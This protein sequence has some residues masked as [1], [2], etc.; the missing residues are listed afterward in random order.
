[1]SPRTSRRVAGTTAP[2]ALAVLLIACAPSPHPVSADRGVPAAPIP[3]A[4]TSAA[5][6]DATT[7]HT[8]TTTTVPPSSPSDGATTTTALP[9]SPTSAPPAAPTT[10]PP[11][12]PTTT[13][14][15]ASDDAPPT[16]LDTARPPAPLLGEAAPVAVGGPIATAQAGERV[17]LD[18]GHVDLIEVTV[19]GARLVVQLKDDTRP[20]GPV[21]R[22]P[23]EVQARVGDAARLQVP[24][25]PAFSFLGPAGSDLWMLPQVQDPA[26]LWPGWSTERISQGQVAGDAVTLRL[27]G[28][29]GPGSFA[30]FTTDQFG[31]PSVIFD[32]DGGVPNSTTVPIRT[33]AHASWAFGAEGVYRVTF[34]V[35]AT[36]S[37][38]TG[39]STPATYVVLVGDATPPIPWE[40]TPTPATTVPP[41]TGAPGGGAGSTSAAAGAAPPSAVSTAGAPGAASSGSAG[42]SNTT[43]TGSLARTGGTV[44]PLAVSGA[45]LVLLGLGARRTARGRRP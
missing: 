30:L 32:G 9:A 13:V 39:V 31:N 20:G 44:L 17:V 42:A 36:L 8:S 25:A 1:M 24:D 16:V 23:S 3:T 28:V 41:G 7:V 34:E 27:A 18:A 40:D 33:H 14:A 2:I 26:L 10:V 15:V 4:S 11:A 45:V 29:D 37:D 35:A 19:D 6:D 21:F 5:T 43:N 12:A 22:L 38:G